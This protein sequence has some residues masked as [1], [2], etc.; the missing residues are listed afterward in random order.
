MS[1][2]VTEALW[3]RLEGHGGQARD[4]LFT[5]ELVARESTGRAPG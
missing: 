3:R 2:A 4:Y 1:A 5:P